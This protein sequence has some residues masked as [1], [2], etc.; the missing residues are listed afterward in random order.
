MEVFTLLNIIYCIFIR[1]VTGLDLSEKNVH[2]DSCGIIQFLFV[3]AW[4]VPPS[5]CSDAQFYC[6]HIEFV[7]KT[8]KVL[9]LNFELSMA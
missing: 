6:N 3:Y 5:S 1:Q 4:K 8:Y 2:S 9:V 7:P